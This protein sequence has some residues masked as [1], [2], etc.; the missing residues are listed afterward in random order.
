[1]KLQPNDP[2]PDFTIEDQDGNLVS[3]SQFKGK[4]IVL[5]FYPQDDTP[6]CTAEACNIRDNHSQFMKNGIVVLGVSV[7][8]LESHTNFIEKYSLPFTLL[9]DVDHQVSETYGVWV[10]KQKIGNTYMGVA[11]T[12]FLINEDQ[13]IYKIYENVQPSQHGEEILADWLGK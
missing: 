1:M 4:K 10:L 13:K 11:R 8:N 9:A 12:T 5:Y 7:D 2:A 6:G 3:L